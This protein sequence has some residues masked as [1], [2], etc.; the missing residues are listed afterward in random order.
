MT[1]H[2]AAGTLPYRTPLPSLKNARI[3]PPD[4]PGILLYG[5]AFSPLASGSISPFSASIRKA[6]ADF[7]DTAALDAQEKAAT[8][9][10]SEA[11]FAPGMHPRLMFYFLSVL[12][13]PYGVEP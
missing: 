10:S 9:T 4:V 11:I 3:D 2:F 1:S 5:P 13:F 6:G 12:N 8:E 7:S